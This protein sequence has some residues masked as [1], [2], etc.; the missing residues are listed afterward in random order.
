MYRVVLIDVFDNGNYGLRCISSSLKQHGF[1]VYNIFAYNYLQ[2]TPELPSD[3]VI[4][5]CDLIKELSPDLIGLNMLSAFGHYWIA[6]LACKIKEAVNAPI[7][8]G[9]PYPSIVPKILLERTVADY[10]CVGEGEET[11]VEFC[12]SLSTGQS[13]G[14]IPGIMTKQKLT[15]VR[16]DPPLELDSLPFQSMGDENTYHITKD[17]QVLKE[18]PILDGVQFHLRAGRGCP[19]HCSYCSNDALRSL[20]SRGKYMRKRSPS[21]VIDEIELHVKLNPKC[22]R[23]WFIDDTF[24]TAKSWVQ[25]FSA[26]Y[27]KRIDMPFIIWHNPV[28][29][30]KENMEMLKSAGLTKAIVGIESASDI[31][32][33]EVFLRNESKEDF[34]KIDKI[35]T[36]LGIVRQYD[37][38]LDHPWESETE[39]EDIVKLLLKLNWPYVTNM[40]SCVILPGTAMAKR[41]VEEGLATE[42]EIIDKM[43]SD[44]LNVS[45]SFQWVRGVPKHGDT[46]RQYWI[47]LIYMTQNNATP[48]WII[49]ML[50]SDAFSGSPVIVK[51]VLVLYK[52]YKSCYRRLINATRRALAK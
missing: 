34:L 5:V 19:F 49:K 29:T 27:K 6:E 48:I 13:A 2:D 26:E 16:R 18:D 8:L 51:A 37:F 1:D 43:A 21:N 40:H 14:D 4:A 45:R 10:V 20:Y 32:R 35:L 23:V 47:L 39:L 41:A 24:P 38:L 28:L 30:K 31:T 44:P 33:K 9:G 7:I 25:E 42:E 17:G 22:N 11:M 3:Q 12:K 46:M 52:F 15:Y 36:D 50:A